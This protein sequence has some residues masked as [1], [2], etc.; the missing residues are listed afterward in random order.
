M[1]PPAASAALPD[2]APCPPSPPP[3]P[4]PCTGRCVAALNGHPEELYAC[5]FLHQPGASTE[6]PPV[7][8]PVVK[9]HNAKHGGGGGDDKAGDDGEG[10]EGDEEEEEERCAL[11]PAA[12]DRFVLAASSESL[13]LWDLQQQRM[14]QQG[15]APGTSGST[16][17]IGTREAEKR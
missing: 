16:M 3:H 1:L 13:F 14:I 15:D 11:N 12:A 17:P 5:S 2:S 8:P 4:P 7:P 9:K 10:E 6:P